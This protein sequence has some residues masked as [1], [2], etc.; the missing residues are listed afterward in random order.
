[1]YR[2]VA[3]LAYRVASSD[4][5]H[6]ISQFVPLHGQVRHAATILPGSREFFPR[7]RSLA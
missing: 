7:A 4:V 2:A 6:S 3:E 5:L 1:M